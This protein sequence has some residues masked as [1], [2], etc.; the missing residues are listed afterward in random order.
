MCSLIWQKKADTRIKKKSM[1]LNLTSNCQSNCSI[2]SFSVFFYIYYRGTFIEF[3]SSMINIC[4]VG[5]SCS[6]KEREEFSAYDQVCT[7]VFIMY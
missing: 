2:G 1:S 5:R 6:Q 3:R 4:P 7:C